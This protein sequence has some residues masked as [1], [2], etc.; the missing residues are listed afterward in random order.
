MKILDAASNNVVLK[1]TDI[2]F[3]TSDPVSL[4]DLRFNGFRRA[5]QFNQLVLQGNGRK[6][7]DGLC[8]VEPLNIR[9]IMRGVSRA[10]GNRTIIY[11]SSFFSWARRKSRLLI[12]SPSLKR[13]K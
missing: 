8:R 1:I 5:S 2:T 7:D 10:R 6:I 3:F 12:S 4:I 9:M 13:I 11:A